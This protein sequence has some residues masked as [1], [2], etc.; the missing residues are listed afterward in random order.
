MQPPV[1]IDAIED[2]F[3]ALA[4]APLKEWTELDVARAIPA[5]K[6]RSCFIAG[7]CSV[8]SVALWRTFLVKWEAYLDEHPAVQELVDPSYI[9]FS[10]PAGGPPVGF[11]ADV[12][13]TDAQ[14]VVVG[15][16]CS[17]GSVSTSLF[18]AATVDWASFFAGRMRALHP[19]VLCHTF[20]ANAATAW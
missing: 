1:R 9:F 2:Q 13:A 16:A 17:D 3:R 6:N 14:A 11:A 19:T 5:L 7:G 12:A 20:K 8:E 10:F 15:V 4:K 18:T